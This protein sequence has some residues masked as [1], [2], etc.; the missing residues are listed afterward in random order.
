MAT[1]AHCAYCFDAL[2][3][4]LC[5]S[6]K[7]VRRPAFDDSTPY[8]LFVTLNKNGSLRGCIGCFSDLQLSTGLVEYTMSSAFHDKRFTPVTVDE[9]RYLE[10]CVSLLTHFESCDNAFDW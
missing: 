5:P 10:I 8:P 3:S 7:V 2:I 4:S 6:S 1:T 9:I